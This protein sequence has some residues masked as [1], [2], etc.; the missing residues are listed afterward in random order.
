M[1]SG[2][3]LSAMSHGTPAAPGIESVTLREEFAYTLDPASTT[4]VYERYVRGMRS[5]RRIAE[6]R[7]VAG[8]R[9]AAG[10]SALYAAI[11]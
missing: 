10:K 6:V 8:G 5:R 9:S 7:N 11:R 4:L 2:P 1:R 3:R